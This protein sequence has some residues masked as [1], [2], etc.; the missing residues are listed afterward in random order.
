V[1]PLPEYGAVCWDPY[2][3]GEVSVLNL[4][5]RRAATFANHTN[6]S[7]WET[8][9][10]R[11][12]IARLCALYKAYT[13]RRAWK[14]IADSLLKPCYLSRDDHDRKISS[15]KERTDVGKHFYVNRT[16]KIGTVYLQAYYN[17]STV[18]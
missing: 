11:R 13:G 7:G 8:L 16:I 14:A 1:R 12:L 15:R 17:L 2:R 5:Q 3:E 10:Q 4:I 18:N 9:A 6:E